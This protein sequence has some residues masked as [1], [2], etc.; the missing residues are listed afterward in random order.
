MTYK[1]PGEAALDYFPC[2]YGQSKLLFRGPRR[3]L[4]GAYVAAIGG[5]ETYGKFV[6]EP[7]PRLLEQALGLP[8]VNFGYM[9]AGTDLFAGEPVVI[10]ACKRARVTVVQLTGAQNLSNR[11]YAVYPRRN[12]RFLRA[13]TLM[14]T[15]FREID[16]TAFSFTGQMLSELKRSVPDKFAL[17]EEELK[18]AWI[19]RMGTLLKKIDSKTVLLW[20]EGG[21]DRY[22]EA[23]REGLGEEPLFVDEDM[24]KAVRPFATDLVRVRVSDAALSTGTEGMLFMPLEEPAAAT[25]PGPKVHEEVADALLP[26]VKRLI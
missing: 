2:R 7:Y 25:M 18:T 5:A 19:A 17:I 3:R 24:V 22:G 10:D 1:F 21:R 13:S 11:F 12:D 26:V 8:V 15:L 14:I 16:F 4:E 20:I 9:N 6:D 23:G